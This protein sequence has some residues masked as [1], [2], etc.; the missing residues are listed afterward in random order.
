LCDGRTPA[1][2]PPVVEGAPPVPMIV[3]DLLVPIAG[4][5][6][7]KVAPQIVT[8]PRAAAD[9]VYPDAVVKLFF[10]MPITGVDTGSFTLTDSHGVQVPALVDQI[11][12]GTW[13][14]F[15]SRVTLDAGETYTARLSGPVCDLSNNCTKQNLM[16]RF[17]VAKAT[18]TAAGDTTIPMGFVLPAYPAAT[19][20]NIARS[21][22]KA[23]NET[24]IAQR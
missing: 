4:G 18:E 12:A 2:E 6:A 22:K 14:L 16:W 8:Y 13:G 23:Q 7:V 10:N 1:T 21:S 17:T 15:P 11:G 5:Q 3:R 9:R 24:R 20:A 19:K